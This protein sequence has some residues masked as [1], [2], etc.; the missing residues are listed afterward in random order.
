MSL[1]T[2]FFDIVP[3]TAQ[4]IADAIVASIRGHAQHPLTRAAPVSDAQRGASTCL[5]DNIAQHGQPAG[6]YQ[7]TAETIITHTAVD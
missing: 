6:H 1:D 7:H 4:G 3:H 2:H 5:N